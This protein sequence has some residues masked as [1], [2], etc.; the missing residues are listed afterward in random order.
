MKKK[1]FESVFQLQQG[2]LLSQIMFHL[3]VF[4]DLK[5]TNPETEITASV[6]TTAVMREILRRTRRKFHLTTT[7]HEGSCS[8]IFGNT[9]HQHNYMFSFTVL[10]VSGSHMLPGH[11]RIPCLLCT[12]SQPTKAPSLEQIYQF[13]SITKQ[14]KDFK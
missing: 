12:G 3:C 9:K 2:F 11:F 7:L 1:I 10:S 5:I 8:S 14:L 4:K 6:G 13:F